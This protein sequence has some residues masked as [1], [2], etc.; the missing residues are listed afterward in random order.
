MS[1]LRS[2]STTSIKT[3]LRIYEGSIKTLFRLCS[4]SSKAL[5]RLYEGCIKIRAPCGPLRG[6]YGYGSPVLRVIWRTSSEYNHTYCTQ[7]T[8]I[9]DQTYDTGVLCQFISLYV[10]ASLCSRACACLYEALF[11]VLF[12][13][14]SS[15]GLKSIILF[16]YTVCVCLRE[17]VTE[18]R[19]TWVK[20]NIRVHAHIRAHTH[21]I[22]ERER[23]S[24]RETHM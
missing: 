11:L 19:K 9:L 22:K 14:Q 6:W 24:E 2:F 10:R 3:L 7:I 18:R 5:W 8:N 1:I 17:R 4:D 13:L 15:I 20:D 21:T 16:S 12:R 23:E